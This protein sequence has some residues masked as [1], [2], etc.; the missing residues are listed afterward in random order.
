MKIIYHIFWTFFI[1]NAVQDIRNYESYAVPEA[2]N[3]HIPCNRNY[4][5]NSPDTLANVAKRDESNIKDRIYDSESNSENYIPMGPRTYDPPENYLNS[6]QSLEGAPQTY[7]SSLFNDHQRQFTQTP[8]SPVIVKYWLT[9]HDD[10]QKYSNIYYLDDVISLNSKL[11]FP[12][13][14]NGDIAL[15]QI[16]Y[17]NPQTDL[18]EF[19]ETVPFT[20]SFTSSADNYEEVIN[21]NPQLT[22]DHQNKPQF[23]SS[24]RYKRPYKLVQE[25][26][27]HST[28]AVPYHQPNIENNKKINKDSSENEL[29]FFFNDNKFD[30]NDMTTDTSIYEDIRSFSI[31]N[32]YIS[33]G[34]GRIKEATSTHYNNYQSRK[35]LSKPMTL[36]NYET[37]ENNEC[38]LSE[39]KRYLQDTIKKWLQKCESKEKLNYSQLYDSSSPP[40]HRQSSKKTEKIS[41]SPED[42]Y[43][44]KQQ[45]QLLNALYKC[46][47]KRTYSSSNEKSLLQFLTKLY[48]I[49]KRSET[50]LKNVDIQKQLDKKETTEKYS[51]KKNE[52]T[53]PIDKSVCLN[54][55]NTKYEVRN[56]T[57]DLQMEFLKLWQNKNDPHNKIN[58]F[59]F[60]KS[61]HRPPKLWLDISSIYYG[62]ENLTITKPMIHKIFPIIDQKNK[63]E[64]HNFR[65]F[66]FDRSFKAGTGIA[67][68]ITKADFQDR[69]ITNIS[70]EPDNRIIGGERVNI[71]KYPYQVAIFQ[72][73]EFICGGAIIKDKFVLTAAHCFESSLD[74]KEY[75]VKAGITNLD[76]DGQSRNVVKIFQHEKYTLSDYDIAII[77]VDNPFVFDKNVAKIRLPNDDICLKIHDVVTI[78]GY[79]TT[80]G[81]SGTLNQ[82][83]FSISLKLTSLERCA[84][85]KLLT[86]ENI[87]I[88]NKQICTDS[89]VKQGTC[90]GDSGGPMVINGYIVGIVSWGSPCAIGDPDVFTNV[91]YFLKWIYNIILKKYGNKR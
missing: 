19:K 67:Y 30:S 58:H 36:N 84:K 40:N 87:A 4:L 43:F 74:A 42:Y 66:P 31:P 7:S 47:R 2:C 71:Q 41:F 32:S 80:D 21:S 48:A 79:G 50:S 22:L 29:S 6:L 28:Y 46:Q 53:L 62:N 91:T 52:S 49:F 72:N 13:F 25:I 55:I 75:R 5:T 56:A 3:N 37:E 65:Y 24:Y 23:E 63:R 16:L 39:L 14:S 10:P 17:Q 12:I 81:V 27:A 85:R 69:N 76:E 35:K 82:D 59:F 33:K 89:P 20:S 15:V 78:T 44:I 90:H 70:N 54:R 45:I 34:K 38:L 83:L 60:T 9:N 18:T 26:P 8:N 1:T 68:H 86:V 57:K 61:E 51:N 73:E 64:I 11:G 77:L 88:T